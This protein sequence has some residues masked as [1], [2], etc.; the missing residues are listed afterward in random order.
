M[1]VFFVKNHTL[2]KDRMSFL[3][4]LPLNYF[5]TKQQPVVKSGEFGNADGSAHLSCWIIRI[6]HDNIRR[7]API[8]ACSKQKTSPAKI[9]LPVMPLL[10]ISTGSLFLNHYE[11]GDS[12]GRSKKNT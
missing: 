8:T 3:L 1:I 2:P 10:P 12:A 5:P 9:R 11:L 4:S 6:N 7:T